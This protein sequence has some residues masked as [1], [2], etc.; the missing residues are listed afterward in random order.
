MSEYTY[1]PLCLRPDI[2]IENELAYATYDTNPVSPGHCLVALNRHV[3]G[4][5]E[6][7]TEEKIAIWALVDEMK[8][9]VDK[10]YEPDGYNVGVNVGET[11]GQSVPHIHIHVMP[12]YKGDVENPKGG[13]RGVIPH[14]Q[15]YT[16]RPKNK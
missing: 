15:K 9:I 13:V 12:R 8:A 5:F 6:A 3:A 14:K 1:C 7:T 10:E 16:L 11:A 4:Y 2:V